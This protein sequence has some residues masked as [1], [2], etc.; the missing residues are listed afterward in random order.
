MVLETERVP[1]IAY[2]VLERVGPRQLAAHVRTL[3]DFLVLEFSNSAGGQ[4]VSKYVET[5]NSII[6]VYNIVPIDRLM[7]CLLC[8]SQNTKYYHYFSSLQALR[9]QEGSEAHV[10][11]FIIQLLLLK[12]PELRN[13]V[14]DFVK[15]NSPD[16]WKQ[17]N[18]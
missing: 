4:H 7:L 10:C 16:H 17:N 14:T 15:E 1:P 3:C 8:T 9:T 5:M 12:P 18:W 6:W 11:F 13:R 2:K